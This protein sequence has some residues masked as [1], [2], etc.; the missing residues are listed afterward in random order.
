M[1]VTVYVFKR[2]STHGPSLINVA[3]G[4]GGEGVEVVLEGQISSSL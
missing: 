3:Q 2:K 4:W 1:D